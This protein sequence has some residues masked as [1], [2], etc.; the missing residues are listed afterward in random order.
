[1]FH[2]YNIIYCLMFHLYNIIYCLLFHLHTTLLGLMG[3]MFFNIYKIIPICYN[4]ITIVQLA[5]LIR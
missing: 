2:L 4:F 5:T 1:M 3:Y